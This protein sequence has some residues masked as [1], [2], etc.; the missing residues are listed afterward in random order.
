MP[1]KTPTVWGAET[2]AAIKA[3][4]VTAGTKVTDAQLAQI[5]EAVKTVTVAS[6]GTGDV[7]PG[8]FSNGGGPVGGTGGPIT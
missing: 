1:L 8:S 3:V 5:W 6:L 4:G 2:A 7:A